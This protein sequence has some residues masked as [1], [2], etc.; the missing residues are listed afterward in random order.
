NRE[1]LIY[2]LGCNIILKS[3]TKKKQE[4]MHGHTNNVSCL[5]VS[6]GG[7]YVASWSGHFH[8]NGWWK[9][10][11]SPLNVKYLVT[12]GGH[13]DGRFLVCKIENREAI[14]GSLASAHSGYG[15]SCSDTLGV[16]E[17]DLPHKITHTE[18]QTGQPKKQ[19]RNIPEE[20]SYFYCGTSGDILKVNLKTKLLHGPWPSET[21]V[22]QGGF[23]KGTRFSWKGVTSI[24]PCGDG[25][26]F[27]VGTEVTQIYC[28]NN[29]DFKEDSLPRSE[30][31]I[32]MWHME[33][34][35]E[36]IHI[37]VPNMTWVQLIDFLC[38]FLSAWNDGKICGFTP[39]TGRLMMT[40]HNAHSCKRIAI[41][42]QQIVYTLVRSVCYHPEEY[43][44]ITSD[45]DRKKTRLENS[46]H[47]Q[48][49]KI[50]ISLLYKSKP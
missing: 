3:L 14:C 19:L 38:C 15:S 25:H 33:T 34:S 4:F 31:D 8:K 29:T 20:G 7:K 46:L 22:Q 27:F 2:P 35:K 41:G 48:L 18:C 11:P 43:Q 39:E 37:T 40:V 47:V 9:D 16:W 44:I 17:L 49:N 26:Q 45:T 23:K 50:Y 24:A 6:K 5:T 28:F 30:N 10:W 13:D 36:V 12:L 21:E 32:W 42:D 1:H